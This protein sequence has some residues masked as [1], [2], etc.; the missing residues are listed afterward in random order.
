MNALERAYCKRRRKAITRRFVEEIVEALTEDPLMPDGWERSF[1]V[2]VSDDTMELFAVDRPWGTPSKSLTADQHA[3]NIRRP[4][5]EVDDLMPHLHTLSLMLADQHDRDLEP[6]SDEWWDRMVLVRHLSFPACQ[7]LLEE[8][9][10][11]RADREREMA[12][13]EERQTDLR[14]ML[15]NPTRE[16]LNRLSELRSRKDPSRVED[17]RSMQENP[18]EE[19]LR[20]LSERKDPW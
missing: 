12:E 10:L 18:T 6:G 13:R 20:R 11:E 19:N 17:L 5:D 4:L 15:E 8:H 14:S 2:H 16:N 3:A 1:T 7:N 9:E